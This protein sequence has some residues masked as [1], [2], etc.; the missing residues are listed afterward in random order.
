MYVRSDVQQGL[1]WAVVARG[2]G[3]LFS[4]HCVYFLRV[5]GY[6][7]RV[8]QTYGVRGGE[9]SQ[10]GRQESDQTH[11]TTEAGHLFSLAFVCAKL[12][13]FKTR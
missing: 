10:Q 12:G 3:V 13:I 5:R 2:G 6:W 8:L 7:S 11:S 4:V 9:G 1:G